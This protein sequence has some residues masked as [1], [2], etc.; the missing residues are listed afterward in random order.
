MKDV[1][2]KDGFILKIDENVFDDMELVDGLVA[3]QDGD[4]TARSRVVSK[5]FGDQKKDLY[6]HLRT[7]SGRVPVAKVDEVFVEVI[8]QLKAKN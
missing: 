6:N 5:V 3:M 1:K 8:S 4:P 7:D 2:L